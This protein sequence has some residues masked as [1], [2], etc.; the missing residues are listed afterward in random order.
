MYRTIIEKKMF[1]ALNPIEDTSSERVMGK[2]NNNA[3]F[4]RVNSTVQL[5]M[6]TI[7]NTSNQDQLS[8]LRLQ[9]KL[10]HALRQ[11]LLDEKIDHHSNEDILE[12]KEYILLPLTLIVQRLHH[13]CY[14]EKTSYPTPNIAKA[15][16]SAMYNCIAE[17][18]ETMA[19][20]IKLVFRAST[21]NGHSN[22]VK[23]QKNQT[24]MST[25]CMMTCHLCWSLVDQSVVENNG[26]LDK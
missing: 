18:A 13:Q 7:Q 1:S 17:I 15:M 10:C 24:S 19:C 6:L 25:K 2:R 4:N 12:A 26:R 22:A 3:L 23:N 11:T 9:T 20:W 21:N 5:L 16:D 14:E 8:K